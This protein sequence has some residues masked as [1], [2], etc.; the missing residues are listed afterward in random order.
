MSSSS[1][2]V[3]HLSE[4]PSTKALISVWTVV[5]RFW[6]CCKLPIFDSVDFRK[7]SIH[8]AFTVLQ[9][10]AKNMNAMTLSDHGL[11]NGSHIGVHGTV[12][13]MPTDGC[14]LLGHLAGILS[15]IASLDVLPS[16]SQSHFRVESHTWE[17]WT[18]TAVQCQGRSLVC[19]SF[20][21]PLWSC[22]LTVT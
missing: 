9:Y 17:L 5:N 2:P 10:Y 7:N 11:G 22:L 13:V 18:S 4:P 14:I 15:S 8:L 3:F 19:E 1:P 12:M 6:F 20:V 16:K 21:C